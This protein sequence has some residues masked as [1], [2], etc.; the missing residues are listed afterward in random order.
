MS[1]VR[2]ARVA[3]IVVLVVAA[4]MG[5]ML[6]VLASGDGGEDAE[7]GIIDSHLLD[8]AAPDVRSSLL[9]GGSFDLS[10]RKGSWVVLNFFNSTCVPCRAEHPELV[11][12][13]EQQASLGP[14][15]AEFYTVVQ[16]GD[17]LDEVRRFFDERGG[18][19]PVLTDENGE[20][21]VDFGVAQVPETFIIDPNGVVRVRWAGVIDAVTLA[22][23]VQQLRNATGL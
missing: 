4:L 15:G 1:E 3:P 17:D 18:D 23:L 9:D 21:F 7:A 10:R 2:R 22:Q 14:L 19:W 8:R 6:W 12:F 13:V 5:G 11:K 20:V 16:I